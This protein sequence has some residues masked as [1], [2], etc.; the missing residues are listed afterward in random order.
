MKLLNYTSKNFYNDLDKL[1]EQRNENDTA[2][3][4]L[5]VKKINNEIKERGDKVL[6]KYISKY[7]GLIVNKKNILL[8]KKIRNS[9]KD[10]I[11]IN[12]IKSFRK[13]IQN[14]TKYH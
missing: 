5:I 11:D 8:S 3:V 4:D 7:D 12:L 9:Y 10:K 2:G 1:I 14:V 13:S 6:F